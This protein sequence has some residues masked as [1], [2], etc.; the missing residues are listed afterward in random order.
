MAGIFIS[1]EGIEGAG[2]TSMAERLEQWLQAAERPVFRTREPGGTQAGEVLRQVILDADIPLCSEAELLLI[3]AARAQLMH[4]V[5]LPKL[6]ED[7]IVILD[8]HIDSTTAYQGFGR[9]VDGDLIAQL[10]G[11]TCRYRKP[12]LTVLL[13]VDVVEGLQRAQKI[14]QQTLIRDRFETEKVEFMQKIREGFLEIAKK[15]PYRF[16]IVPAQGDEESVW[17]MLLAEIKE[18]PLITDMLIPR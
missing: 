12:D 6:R 7:C 8:R 2:K 3:E 4:E 5:I 13:D 9:G 11:F 17:T 10:N 15:E 16:L 14:T 18:K 1:M